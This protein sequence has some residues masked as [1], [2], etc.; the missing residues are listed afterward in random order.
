MT[1]PAT[2]AENPTPATP[3]GLSSE[4]S[5]DLTWA[6][7]QMHGLLLSRETV[8][9]ALQLVTSL[10]A[11]TTAGT[12]GAAVTVVD[13]HGKRSRAAS[14]QAVEQADALQYEYDEGPCLTAWRTGELVR[15]DDTAT[16]GRWPRWNDAASRMGVRSVLSSPLLAGGESIGAMKVYCER[17]MNYGPHD[18]HVMR[19]LAGQAAILLANSQSLAEARRLSRQLTEALASRDVVARAT[20]VLLA[21]GAVGEQ[22]A[23]ATL[24]AA[25][26][27]TGKPV[28]DVAQALVAAVTARNARAAGS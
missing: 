1:D 22:E 26:R 13:E 6:L 17:P 27:Q 19:L 12:L 18:E 15:I 3:D 16:D 23:F 4:P 10:A 5:V 7:N 25:A 2:P 11:T 8:D 9:T 28:Q 24:A 20:G 14:N 21:R